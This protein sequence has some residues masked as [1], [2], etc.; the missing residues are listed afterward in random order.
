MFWTP[1]HLNPAKPSKLNLKELINTCSA[2]SQLA[3]VGDHEKDGFAGIADPR[4]LQ[5]VMATVISDSRAAN[6]IGSGDADRQAHIAD[7]WEKDRSMAS[8]I[9]KN[10]PEDLALIPIPITVRKPIYEAS[11]QP[12]L[13][14]IFPR[15]LVNQDVLD[16]ESKLIPLS[17]TQPGALELLQAMAYHTV[18]KHQ[19]ADRFSR[20]VDFHLS[21]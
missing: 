13:A 18:V 9:T 2:I 5:S 16:E 7:H 21:K 3:T 8:I 11:S 17:A 19:G 4:H 20:V 14:I 10:F 12:D 6:L 15:Y 1:D